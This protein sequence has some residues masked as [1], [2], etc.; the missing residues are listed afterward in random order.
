MPNPANS[1][2]RLPADLAAPQVG[3][4][5]VRSAAD[6]A[7]RVLEHPVPRDRF[8]LR[9]CR[10]G[11]VLNLIGIRVSGCLRV[12]C[13]PNQESL[14]RFVRPEQDLNVLPSRGINRTRLFQK[15]GPLGIRLLQR[16]VE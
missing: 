12:P 8:V 10:F 9:P 13:E 2:Y 16:I 6:A 4:A 15:C 1:S 7:A 3:S 11:V 14:R 5:G